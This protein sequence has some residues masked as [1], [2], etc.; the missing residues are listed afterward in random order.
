MLEKQ[1]VSDI[2]R[3]LAISLSKNKTYLI[4]LAIHPDLQS[5]HSQY[6]STDKGEPVGGSVHDLMKNRFQVVCADYLA[7]GW[8]R[9]SFEMKIKGAAN[10]R[11]RVPAPLVVLK[12]HMTESQIK[13]LEQFQRAY[14]GCKFQYLQLVSK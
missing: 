13:D 5:N 9:V 12:R 6:F 4:V 8:L 14:R 10:W 7:L 11:Q 1:D 3:N 2:K